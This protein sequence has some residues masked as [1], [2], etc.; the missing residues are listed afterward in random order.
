MITI[1]CTICQKSEIMSYEPP[2]GKT[3]LSVFPRG[4]S[5]VIHTR[6]DVSPD[7]MFSRKDITQT[8]GIRNSMIKNGIS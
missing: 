5:N 7:L 2:R 6:K 3:T 4:G 8:P 1:Q